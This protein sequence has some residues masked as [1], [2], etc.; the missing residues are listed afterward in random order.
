MEQFF[1]YQGAGN[2]F[3]MV[4]NRASGFHK[5]QAHIARLCHRRFGIGADGLILLESPIHS[6]DDFKMVY[7]NADGREST[8][9][10][11]GGRCIVKFAQAL[12][13]ITDKCQFSAIDGAHQATITDGLVSLKMTD[14]DQ[15][16][17]IGQAWCLNTGSPHYVTFIKDIDNLDVDKAG[18][19]IRHSAA[20]DKEGINV[21]FVEIGLNTHKVRT[22]ERGVEAETYSCG[23]GVTAVAIALFVAKKSTKECA[24]L[25]TLGGKLSVH[26]KS[27]ASGFKDIWL[28]G[29]AKHTFTGTF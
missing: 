8:M 17:A 16:D 4:D 25:E 23:T 27:T 1:K 28:T 13:I 2:D 14:V 21:N 10:G 3:I 29:P 7:Y 11:N 20:F 15:V 19:S 6:G 18:R 24:V 22:Y 5:E 12:G 26:F 9:C